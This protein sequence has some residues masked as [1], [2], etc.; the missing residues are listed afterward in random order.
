MIRQ[1]Y[2]IRHFNGFYLSIPLKD[3]NLTYPYLL[4]VLTNYVLSKKI[5]LAQVL[6][7]LNY[8]TFIKIDLLTKT[9]LKNS[10]NS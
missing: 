1:F 6:H 5:H 9:E 3:I 4:Y 8:Y 2:K 7:I 10:F